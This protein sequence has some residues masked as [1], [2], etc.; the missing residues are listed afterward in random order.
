[1]R[2]NKKIFYKN[3]AVKRSFAARKKSLKKEL[4]ISCIFIG[5]DYNMQTVTFRRGL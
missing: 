1:M 2:K 4:K 3:G 5:F